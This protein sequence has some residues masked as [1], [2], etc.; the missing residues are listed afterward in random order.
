M[1]QIMASFARGERLGPYEM[2]D[3]IG[4]GGMGEVWKARDTRLDRIVAIKISKEQF[5]E[6]FER[7]ARAVAALNHPH[8][9]QLY[10]VGPNYLVMEF[11][12]GAPLKGPLPLEKAVEYAGQ[13]LEALDAAHRKGITHRDLKPANILVTKQGI[14]LLD[15]GLAKQ[16]GPLAAGDATLTQALTQHGQILGTLQ[17]MAPEQLQ[18]KDT[19]ARSDL[20]AFGCV[21]YE[22]LT[23]KRAFEGESAASVIAA[24]LEREPLPLTAAPPLERVVR[25]SLAKDPDQ[26]FQT[27]RDLKAALGWAMEQA[28]P[29]DRPGGLSHWKWVAAT[30]LVIGA[31]GGWG[32]AH[33]RQ[34]PADDRVF[35]LPL[36][37]PERG[38]FV[39]GNSV[40]GIALSPDGRTAAFV[41]SG[42]GKTGLWVRPLDGTTARLIAG[43]E[44]A[45]YPFWSPDSKSIAYFTINKLQRVD[46]A[47]GTLVTVC[48]TPAI[49][50]GGSWGGDGRILFGSL[51]DGIFQVPASGGTPTPLT[52]TGASL[53]EAFHRWPQILPGGRFLY[54]VQS[55][56]PEN[57]GV[58][59]ASLARPGERV[60][61][62]TTDTN[63]VYAPGSDGK[64]YLLWLRGETLFAQEFDPGTP[65]LAGEPHVVASPVAKLASLGQ[66]QV[67]V[68]ASG[69]LL[70]SASN[71]SSQ[72]TWLDRAGKPH[73][74]VGE[75]G[76]YTMFRLSADGRNVVA[77]RDRPGGNDLWLLEVERAA[78]RRFT[79]NSNVNIY[80]VW[81]PDGR[82]IVF[83]TSTPRNLFRKDS[84]GSGSEQRL[85][86]SPNSQLANDWSRDGRWVVYQET[87]PGSQRDLWI[88]PMSPDGKLAAEGKPK[89]YLQTRFDELW[90][91]FSPEAPPRWMAYQSDETGR[92]EVY[93]R[94]FPE[95]RGEFQISTGG[96]QYPQWGADGR[97]IF[98]VSPDNRLMV[99]SLK[100]GADTVTPSTP[101]ELFPL[102]VLDTGWSPY[103]TAPDGQRFLL[104]ATLEQAGA[105]L[106][107][108]VNWLAL[109]KKGAGA[110]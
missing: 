108:I 105:P 104:R 70:Y 33:F 29:A 93:I 63:V 16:A 76:E 101:R 67:S 5:S 43:T 8:I 14:K 54:L 40:G 4:A 95:P 99:V 68:S 60:R 62:L 88:L 58:Y 27:V 49:G 81:S 78:A 87:T 64:S 69:V 21:L 97:E 26:R 28:P 12:E 52:T 34:P 39:F 85:T 98:Y 61:L 92:Y 31:L 83:T 90:A 22:M 51:T 65:K 74:A 109:L 56:K 79:A 9:C 102:P 19:D 25:R 32:V 38:Q 2:L 48:E 89:L 47:G 44:G 77:S 110:P 57:D 94:A 45:A 23:G 55:E 6:R 18:G 75:P 24:I 11:I 17:Y 7:E 100:L 41:A 20:F 86:Q 1:Q 73:G 15:F 82:T 37:P 30:A 96:G 66:M 59:V 72:F 46:L 103:D 91:R 53:G 80:P 106:T 10:D 50:R 42:K 107:V 3:A 84:S 13:I 36:N 71:T 35:R